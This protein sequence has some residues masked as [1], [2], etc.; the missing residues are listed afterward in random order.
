MAV[1][2]TFFYYILLGGGGLGGGGVELVKDTVC[3]FG[4]LYKW[5]VMSKY[6]IDPYKQIPK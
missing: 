6:T 2:I 3:F 5:L 4:K 1:K